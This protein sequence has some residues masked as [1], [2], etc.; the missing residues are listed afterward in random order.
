LKN[1][2][3]LLVTVGAGLICSTNARANTIWDVTATLTD[4][5]FG[6]DTISGSFTV[7]SLFDVVAWN[8]T[9]AGPDAISYKTT[10]GS[11]ATISDGNREITFE[12]SFLGPGVGLFLASALPSGSGSAIKLQAGSFPDS[13]NVCSFLCLNGGDTFVSGSITDPPAVPEP[14]SVALVVPAILGVAFLFRRRKVF[15]N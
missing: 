15:A 3:A 14:A 1:S 9:V 2:L 5:A 8:I 11:T 12:D 6:T 4:G 10:D 13:T 7:D